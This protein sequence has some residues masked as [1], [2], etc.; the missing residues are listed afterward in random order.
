MADK[1]KQPQQEDFDK[2]FEDMKSGKIQGPTNDDMGPDN[3]EQYLYGYKKGLNEQGT[4]MPTKDTDFKRKL[5][6][7]MLLTDKEIPNRLPSALPTDPQLNDPFARGRNQGRDEM[8]KSYT[9]EQAKKKKG[10]KVL[11]A[12]GGNVRGHGIEKRGKTKGKFI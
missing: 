5:S 4:Y 1:D 9:E 6:Q 11:A 12:K 7:A 2:A 8:A 10:G 3:K